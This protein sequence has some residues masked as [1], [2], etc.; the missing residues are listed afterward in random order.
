MS[1]FFWIFFHLFIKNILPKNDAN[2]HNTNG[3]TLPRAFHLWSQVCCSSLSSLA[4]LCLH[5]WASYCVCVLCVSVCARALNLQSSCI[6]S[7]TSQISF[8]TPNFHARRLESQM[9]LCEVLS[10]PLPLYSNRLIVSRIFFSVHWHVFF[11]TLLD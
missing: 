2:G 4:F 1:I 8:N 3:C 7:I 11:H 6:Q 10:T 9:R 5:L